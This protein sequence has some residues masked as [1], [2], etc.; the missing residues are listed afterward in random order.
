MIPLS[1]SLPP[2][3]NLTLTTLLCVVTSTLVSK[4]HT[5][6]T[7]QFSLHYYCLIFRR[8]SVEHLNYELIQIIQIP[9]G[10]RTCFLKKTFIHGFMIKHSKA[11]LCSLSPCFSSMFVHCVF[12]SVYVVVFCPVLVFWG[13]FARC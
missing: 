2:Y 12:T 6:F 11:S 9:Q 10:K 5:H 7:A 8:F 4:S 1:S 3:L 13:V